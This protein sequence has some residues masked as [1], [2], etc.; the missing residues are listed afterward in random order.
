MIISIGI[1]VEKKKKKKRQPTTFVG[2][3]FYWYYPDITISFTL[4]M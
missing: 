1:D 3:K 4:I 2:F